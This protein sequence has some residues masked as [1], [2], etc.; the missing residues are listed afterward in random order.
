MEAEPILEARLY[1]TK[2]GDYQLV[3]HWWSQ[4]RG[5]PLAETVLPPIGVM[6]ERDGSPVCAIWCYECFGIGVAFIENPVSRPGL[7][8]QET[9][10]F[11]KVAIDA[12]IALAKSHGDFSLFK[13]YACPRVSL[14]MPSLGFTQC[15]DD[16]MT[17]FAIRVD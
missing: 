2:T 13:T 3:S 8:I 15:T 17:G 10:A 4:R 9:K 11:F 12:C 14:V 5:E 7:T 1:G 16:S 6:V